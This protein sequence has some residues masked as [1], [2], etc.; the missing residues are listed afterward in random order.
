MTTPQITI[1]DATRAKL[2]LATTKQNSHNLKQIKRKQKKMLQQKRKQT[3][4][5][6]KN[7]KQ[8]LIGSELLT[9][10]C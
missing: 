10:N 3:K 5:Q 1:H 7:A 4:Q 9:K 8:F 6:P 2:L